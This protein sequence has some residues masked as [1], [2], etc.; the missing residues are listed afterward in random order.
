VGLEGL[1]SQSHL[2]HQWKP[3][4]SKAVPA[5][6]DLA[7]LGILLSVFSR[8][9][10][11]GQGARSEGRLGASG[12]RQCKEGVFWRKGTTHHQVRGAIVIKDVGSYLSFDRKPIGA[13]AD[14]HFLDRL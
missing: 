13:E 2:F 12:A 10:E 3:P 11:K 5:A 4:L 1:D 7:S 8:L 6:N 9:T 14:C